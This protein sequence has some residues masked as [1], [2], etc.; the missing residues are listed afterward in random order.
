[1]GTYF[2]TE[3]FK[4][5]KI[6]TSPND[7][8]LDVGCF[9]GYW[10]STQ[11]AKEKIGLDIDIHR[12][13]KNIRYKKGSALNIPLKS[14]YFD[15]VFAFDVIEH[16]PA[17]T[18]LQFLRELIRVTKI[19]GSVILTVPSREIKVFPKQETI[20]N[21]LLIDA[22][23]QDKN[24]IVPSESLKGV[25]QLVNVSYN[26]DYQASGTE[27]I[28][29]EIRSKSATVTDKNHDKQNSQMQISVNQYFQDRARCCV[30]LVHTIIRFV[31]ERN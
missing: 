28:G 19:S 15:K 14:G 7:K 6:E 11:N 3:L 2:R 12:K 30:H 29:Q 16:I 1:M 23:D 18:E 24:A 22:Y 5:L 20:N 25:V 27:V 26:G 21:N 31:W 8:V 9:D 17:N 10:L 13:Y 4:K